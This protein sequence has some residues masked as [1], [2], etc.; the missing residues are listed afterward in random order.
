MSSSKLKR[1]QLRDIES[2][3][4]VFLDELSLTSALPT[5]TFAVFDNTESELFVGEVSAQTLFFGREELV[6]KIIE[7]EGYNSM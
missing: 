2:S 5:Q 1:R 7:M 6:G 4:G 3:L